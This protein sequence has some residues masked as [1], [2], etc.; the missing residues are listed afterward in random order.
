MKIR[1]IPA[2]SV[3]RCIPSILPLTRMEMYKYRKLA[4]F[5]KVVTASVTVEL[6]KFK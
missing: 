4:S 1:V 5:I 2:T 6:N 3:L